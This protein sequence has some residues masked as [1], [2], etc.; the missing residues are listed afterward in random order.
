MKDRYKQLMKRSV[1]DAEE[2]AKYNYGAEG[3]EDAGEEFI[4]NMSMMLYSQRAMQYNAKKAMARNALNNFDGN[5]D[6]GRM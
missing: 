3:V 1:K 5:P 4:M 2:I 6:M